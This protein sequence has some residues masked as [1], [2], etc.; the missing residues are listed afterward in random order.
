MIAFDTNVC[1][2]LLVE[3][4]AH[5][6]KKAAVL[7]KDTMAGAHSIFLSHL[8][9]CETV[10]VLKFGYQFSRTEIVKTI[11]LLL[12]AKGFEIPEKDMVLRALASYQSKKGDFSDYLIRE[13]AL[14]GKCERIATFD[15]AL[16][17]DA[18]FFSP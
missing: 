13:H 9:L 15:K 6:T 7:L 3:D 11:R 8:V 1:V 10:C 14:R 18:S 4:D 2:R 12:H 16:L 5:Q 17:G